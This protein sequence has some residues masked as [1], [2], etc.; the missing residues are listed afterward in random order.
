MKIGIVGGGVTGLTAAYYLT[1]NGCS[2]TIFEKDKDLGGLL[3]SFKFRDFYL[4]RYYHHFFRCDTELLNLVK[5]LGLE[6]KTIWKETKMGFF[7][8]GKAY[9]FGTP[10]ELLKFSPLSIFDRIKFG[11]TIL[12]LQKKNNWSDLDS[13]TAEEWLKK[14]S[15][16]RTYKVIWKPLLRIKFGDKFANKISAAWIWGRINPRAKSRSKGFMK[17]ELGYFEGGFQTL[18]DK[19]EEEIKNKSG[20][21]LKKSEIRRIEKFGGRIKIFL[22]KEEYVFDKVIFTTPNPI[23][24]KLAAKIPKTFK[25]NLQQIE[26]QSIICSTFLL[27]KQLSDIYWLNISDRRIPFGGVIEHTNFVSKEDYKDFSVV[28]VFNYVQKDSEIYNYSNE[29]IIDIYKK[30]LKEIFPEFNQ[31]MIEK[32]F[33]HRD[34]YGTPVY[35]KNYSKI[36][37]KFETPLKNLFL[38]NTS[39]IYPFDRNTNNSVKLG[40]DIAEKIMEQ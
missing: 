16:K 3:G 29:R 26:Y 27:R 21:I 30:G 9:P 6:E 36:K 19:I 4:E 7:V 17:E 40:R 14:F 39:M 20:E 18:V 34:D 15:G 11:L 10:L 35:V 23:F 8:D 37:P 13:I 22:E 5:E 31:D 28:Y 24:L 12:Y 1:K 2:V 33:I 25:E 38:A 32:I